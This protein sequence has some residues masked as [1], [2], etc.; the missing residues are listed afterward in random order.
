MNDIFFKASQAP[1]ICVAPYPCEEEFGV[2]RNEALEE[3]YKLID[4]IIDNIRSVRSSYNL[5]VKT[6]TKL[7]LRCTDQEV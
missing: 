5:A 1:S 4:R 3:K 2:W 6:K 7:I